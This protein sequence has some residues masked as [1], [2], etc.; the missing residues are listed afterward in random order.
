MGGTAALLHKERSSQSRSACLHLRSVEL[1]LP[2]HHVQAE[3]KGSHL[4]I[5]TPFRHPTLRA[6]GRQLG[7]TRA[8]RRGGPELGLQN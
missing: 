4:G 5:P 7:S 8:G 1:H 3:P 2:L 6:Y